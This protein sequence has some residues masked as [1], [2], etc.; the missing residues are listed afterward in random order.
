MQKNSSRQRDLYYVAVKA[1]LEKDGKLFIFRDKYGD[2]D[3]PGGRIKRYEF[4]KPL[5]QVLKRKMDEELGRSIS[6]KLGSP[7]VFMRHERMEHDTN[8]T[9]RIFAIGYLATLVRGNIRL[10]DM[11]T[12]S[13]WIPIKSFD[14]KHYFTGGWLK[15]V[16]EYLKLRRK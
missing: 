6:Y 4:K 12:E 3:L 10:S 1:F 5:E 8:S 7:V 11:H 15:G 2:W 14:P 13:A 16:Q 9:V